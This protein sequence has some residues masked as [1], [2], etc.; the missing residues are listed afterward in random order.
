MQ[1]ATA[2]LS[3]AMQDIEDL[4]VIPGKVEDILTISPKLCDASPRL[5][6]ARVRA[7]ASAQNHL[8]PLLGVITVSS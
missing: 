7:A 4:P 8:S 1:A 5:S 6:P 2:I 3:K